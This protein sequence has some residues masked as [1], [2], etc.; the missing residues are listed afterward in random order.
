MVIGRQASSRIATMDW[1]V[2]RITFTKISAII[3]SQ[4]N[5]KI[6]RSANSIRVLNRFIINVGCDNTKL[7]KCLQHMDKTERYVIECFLFKNSSQNKNLARHCQANC[8]TNYVLH[9]SKLW[10]QSPVFVD[11]SLPTKIKTHQKWH[12]KSALLLLLLLLFVLL[13]TH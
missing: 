8:H 9:T 1:K 13:L 10:L 12:N 7:I 2:L 4:H 5:V 6:S 11:D 3:S